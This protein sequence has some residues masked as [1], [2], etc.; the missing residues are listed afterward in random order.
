MPTLLVLR[1]AKSDHDQGVPD[2]ERVL[3]ARGKKDANRMGEL[4][5]KQ[6]LL[7]DRVLSSTAVR[8]RDTAERFSESAGFSGSI[9]FL[10]SLYHAEPDAYVQALAT[11]GGNAETVMVVGHNPGLEALVLEL[12]DERVELPTA[13]L[14]RC[15]VAVSAWSEMSVASRAEL[16]AIFR[17]RDLD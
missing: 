9:E 5:K 16:A 7:P 10:E 6:G 1:H 14:V 3:N 12:T 4:A 8:A 17:P 11:R 2:H 15:P 13:A